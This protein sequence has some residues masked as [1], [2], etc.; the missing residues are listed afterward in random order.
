MTTAR[1][2]PR[3]A[4]MGASV[5][6]AYDKIAAM[7]GLFRVAQPLPGW[8]VDRVYADG[9][10]GDYRDDGTRYGVC[11]KYSLVR[12]A[13]ILH[14]PQCHC[15]YRLVRDVYTL[16]QYIRIQGRTADTS[17]AW[18]LGA[19]QFEH[20][21][22]FVLTRVLGTGTAAQITDP[23]DPPGTVRV[24][25]TRLVEVYVP[26]THWTEPLPA[27]LAQKIRNRYGVKV[28]QMPGDLYSFKGSPDTT[29]PENW[30]ACMVPTNWHEAGFYGLNGA[31][32]ALLSAVIDSE[33]YYLLVERTR[34]NLREPGLWQ[35]PGGSLEGFETPLEAAERETLEELEVPDLGGGTVLG[36][37]EYVHKSGWKYTS[38][39]VALDEVPECTV[40][41]FEIGDAAWFNEAGIL[42]LAESG[43]LVPG[44]AEKL[45]E[46]LALFE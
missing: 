19:G 25:G 5:W 16:L 33:R 4:Y 45:P 38:Y 20:N 40:D 43:D 31:A 24:S 41:G 44:L 21:V 12:P 26:R 35:L 34:G 27:G 9:T 32:G 42:G 39:A 3:E 13:A 1:I 22:G 46:L 36:E 10:I 14:N 23:T 15:G 7:P 37:V 18:G 30:P 2:D 29:A 28:R 17:L 11:L 8:R 6:A